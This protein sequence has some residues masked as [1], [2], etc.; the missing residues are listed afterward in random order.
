LNIKSFTN[1]SNNNNNKSN[2]AKY[3]KLI[4]S[5]LELGARAVV[6]HEQLPGSTRKSQTGFSSRQELDSR[7]TDRNMDLDR[8]Q[9]NEQG[10]LWKLA[11][12]EESESLVIP[13]LQ[14]E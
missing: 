11:M 3:T 13:Q 5:F 12:D 1:N 9:E 4:V 7:K 8:R 14:T 2:N 6:S 10:P